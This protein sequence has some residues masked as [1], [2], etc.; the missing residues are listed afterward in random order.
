MKPMPRF[1]S[2]KT[3]EGFK[4]ATLYAQEKGTATN[5]VAE[6]RY[7]QG[8]LVASKS[9]YVI[10][11]ETGEHVVVVGDDFYMKHEPYV[12]GYYVQ[13]ADG[14][15]SFSP[16]EAFEAGYVQTNKRRVMHLTIDDSLNFTVD[17]M[18]NMLH[19]FTDVIHGDLV[20]AAN[21]VVA[22]LDGVRAEFVDV[23]D[24]PEV[25]LVTLR[26]L[27]DSPFE[28]DADGKRIIRNRAVSFSMDSA[29]QPTAEQFVDI[30]KT[31]A[32]LIDSPEIEVDH[33]DVLDYSVE[34]FTEKDTSEL[35]I[36]VTI[37]D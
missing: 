21:I 23:Q 35:L 12:G 16:A 4:I 14:Y 1:V 27:E 25:E 18:E 37:K 30:V 2:H 28:C 7:W 3:V 32:P 11:D 33:P 31:F 29:V 22:T 26:I 19:M 20:D 6:P 10:K 17:D 36:S 34:A 8:R 24:S 15:Q 9:E 13:Y 5:T